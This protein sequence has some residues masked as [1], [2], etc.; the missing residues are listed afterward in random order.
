[1]EKINNNTAPGCVF[2]KIASGEIPTE[3]LYENDNVFIIK[4]INPKTPVHLLVI[5]KKHIPTLNE[6]EDASLFS[7]LFK[8][9]KFITKKMNI[10]EYKTLINTGASAGQIV[11]HLHMHIMAQ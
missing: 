3:K 4:D 2:C 5:T 6:L 7:D 1:M 10:K 11:F 8:A 9:V